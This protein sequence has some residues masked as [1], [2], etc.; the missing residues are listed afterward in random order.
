MQIA[1]TMIGASGNHTISAVLQQ[2]N[3]GRYYSS[4]RA[5]DHP[6]PENTLP[7]G[8]VPKHVVTTVGAS[9]EEA[10]KALEDALAEVLGTLDWVRWYHVDGRPVEH[11]DSSSPA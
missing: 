11:R 5:F 8:T 2:D 3:D 6:N 9:S 1:A 7:S 4:A 10:K